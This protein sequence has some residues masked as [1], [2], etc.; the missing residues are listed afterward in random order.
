MIKYKLIDEDGYTRK[1]MEGEIFWL[2]GEWK[3]TNGTGDALCTKDVIH[4]YDHPKLAVI[5]NPIHAE[6]PN[7]RLI[8]IEVDTVVAHN[9]LKGGCKRAKFM[10]ELSMPKITNEQMVEFAIRCAL[11][12]YE[13]W[14]KNDKNNAWK[15]WADNWLN[16]KDRT[17][18]GIVWDCTRAA[19][20]SAW[21]AEV[22]TRA[23]QASTWVAQ[24]SAW[25]AEAA[26][27]SIKAG[28][29]IAEKFIEI[30]DNVCSS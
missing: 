22:S 13:L 4:F 26:W 11:L 12:T 19:Q 17:S 30:I 20:A 29:R 9:G 8:K 2:D 7:P 5:F 18:A 21:A 23:T 28:T 24:A 1:G 27:T 14:S 15:R 16:G 10:V 3:K 25:A 6:I